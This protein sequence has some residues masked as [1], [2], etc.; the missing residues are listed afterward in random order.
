MSVHT[1]TPT[2]M[3]IVKEGDNCRPWVLDGIDVND[4][5][6]DP[7]TGRIYR[8]YT[9][10]AWTFATFTEAVAALSRFPA[11]VQGV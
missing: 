7:E 5:R 3:R 8:A 11:Y 4:E 10:E 6:V 1:D 9:E 2:R